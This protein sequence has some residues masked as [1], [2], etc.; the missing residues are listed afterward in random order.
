MLQR[1]VL[2]VVFYL[3]SAGIGAAQQL[4][5]GQVGEA[6]LTSLAADYRPAIVLS[7]ANARDT[8]YAVVD[9]TVR[10]GEEGVTCVYT[11]HFVIFD[12]DPSCDPSMDVYNDDGVNGINL[13][14]SW[15]QS[16]GAGEGNAS[17]DMHHLFP[18]RGAVNSAR[19]NM[20][21]GEIADIDVTRWYYLDQDEATPPPV[22]EQ[23][24]W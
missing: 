13:E 23:H 22:D 7:G 5:P 15:P 19:G 4:F 6:L 8:L 20:P 18:T 9:M 12:C 10:D 17:S 3:S 11:D 2:L 14:H 21:F 16:M 24:L 1:W